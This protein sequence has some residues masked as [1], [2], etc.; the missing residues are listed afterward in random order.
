MINDE[1]RM[2]S[3]CPKDEG[4]GRLLFLIPISSFLRLSSFVLRHHRA[5]CALNGR[6]AAQ[7]RCATIKLLSL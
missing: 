1:G 2:K 6:E 5:S 3:E 7:R 4:N